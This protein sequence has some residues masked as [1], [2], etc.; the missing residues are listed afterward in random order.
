MSLQHTLRALLSG[1]KILLAAV[2][3]VPLVAL[4]ASLLT[5][6]SYQASAKL[7]VSA[8]PSRAVV[9]QYQGNLFAQQRVASYV[10]MLRG[11]EIAA[12]TLARLGS[13]EAP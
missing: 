13:N 1:W 11:R 3:V 5:P 9:D 8:T 7:F 4:G 10:Q 6:A 2:L 12:R